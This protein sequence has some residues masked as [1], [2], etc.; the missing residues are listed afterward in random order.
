MKKRQQFE[1]AKKRLSS[2]KAI[3]KG[4]LASTAGK[5]EGEKS[6]IASRVIK[7]VKLS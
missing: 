1:K 2:K 3:Y 7:S 4:G 6:G 5:Y